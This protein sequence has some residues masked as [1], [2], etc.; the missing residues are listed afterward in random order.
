MGEGIEERNRHGNLSFRY[1]YGPNLL[2]TPGGDIDMWR[3]QALLPRPDEKTTYPLQV[4]GTP[5]RSVLGL[6]IP[7]LWL[8]DETVGPSASNKDRATA[9][10]IDGGLRCGAT[11]VATASTGNAAVSTAIGAA[12]AGLTAVIF[13]PEDC[14]AA[15][16]DAMTAAGAQVFRVREGY[17]AAFDLSRNVAARFGWV[18]RNTGVN[19]VTIEAKKTVAFE[20]WEQLGHRVPDVVA[21]PVGD[22]PTLV[23]LAKGFRE[24]KACRAVATLPRIIAVQ[25]GG[26]APL[27]DAWFGRTTSVPDAGATSADGIAVP[28]PSIGAW[29]LDE[30]RH[31]AGTFV[32][33]SEEEISHAVRDLE[34]L[35]GVRS[36]PAGAAA[37]AGLRQAAATGLVASGETAVTLVTGA[38]LPPQRR[39]RGRRGSVWTIHARPDAVAEAL[40]GIPLRA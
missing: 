19:P 40:A 34:Q 16:V 37:L 27:A 10:V 5:L 17:R 12:A 32:T 15:K 36:E 33:V 8:K 38:D 28:S 35:A 20:I 13:V 21:V 31:T 22:G 26:C 39:P 7:D 9:L 1:G 11:V 14:L 24:L 23:G 18:D 2:P 6:G 3:Y 4:G 30:V 29:T 25:A